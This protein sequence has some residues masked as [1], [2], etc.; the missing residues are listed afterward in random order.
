MIREAAAGA[1]ENTKDFDARAL[2]IGGAT[3]LYHLFPA[4]EAEERIIFDRGRWKSDIKHL[5]S[6]L[7][8]TSTPVSSAIMVDARGIHIEAFRH[9]HVMPAVV[10][11]RGS[12]HS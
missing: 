8:E 1:G 11:R 5:Y 4:D 6:R 2:K 10:R 12:R 3:D 9:G 7:S